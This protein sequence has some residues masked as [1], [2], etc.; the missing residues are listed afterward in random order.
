[1]KTIF[2]L[3][4][5]LGTVACSHAPVKTELSPVVKDS[6]ELMNCVFYYDL[7]LQRFSLIKDPNA[8]EVDRGTVEAHGLVITV[9][10]SLLQGQGG[11]FTELD[12]HV[13]GKKID[14]KVGSSF[15][16]I[17][18]GNHSLLFSGKLINTNFELDKTVYA[19]E[20]PIIK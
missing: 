11:T 15:G 17:P 10:R 7:P 2:P 13:Q 20:C 6:T 9:E 5:L 1:M 19:I 4:M 18:N 14:F 16:P 12:L 8:K 3:L